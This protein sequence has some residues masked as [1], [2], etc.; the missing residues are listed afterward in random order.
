MNVCCNDI[1]IATIRGHD[2]C[3][4]LLIK[5]GANIN[6]RSETRSITGIPS[7]NSGMTPL[8]FAAGNNPSPEVITVLVD[9]GADAKARDSDGKTA[10]DYAEKNEKLKG[11]KQYQDLK[12]ALNK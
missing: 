10:F 11:T 5:A 6:A 8:M 2:E 7:Q 9:A 12:D 3:L 4:S 1:F